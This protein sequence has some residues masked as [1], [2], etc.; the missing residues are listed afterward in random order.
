M[1]KEHDAEIRREKPHPADAHR[2]PEIAL[3]DGPVDLDPGEKR[4]QDSAEPGKPIDPVVELQMDEI[5]GHGADHDLGQRHRD[6]QPDRQH[7]RHQREPD[8]Q[9]GDQPD[10]FHDSPLSS[11]VT[12][13][14]CYGW[15]ERVSR[16]SARLAA[17]R[18]APAALN[19]RG[20][21][22][23]PYGG[24]GETPSHQTGVERH[25]AASWETSMGPT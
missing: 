15:R 22:Y 3:D 17:G 2:R 13:D 12:W 24:F 7:R 14:R 18:N 23:Q 8:P 4:E 1:S 10:M 19:A 21:S 16:V 11:P 6:C 25:T 5:A 9:R 20:R